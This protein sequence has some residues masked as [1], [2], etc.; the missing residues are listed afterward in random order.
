MTIKVYFTN[1]NKLEIKDCCDMNSVNGT[2]QIST[3][4]GRRFVIVPENVNYFV[5]EGEVEDD[6]K[7]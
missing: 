7:T 6:E 3:K 4:D 5:A 2:V 1:G